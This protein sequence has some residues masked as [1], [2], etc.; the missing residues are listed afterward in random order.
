MIFGGH[1]STVANFEAI[2]SKRH[3]GNWG[4]ELNALDLGVKVLSL[5]LRN[6]S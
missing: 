2:H 6:F 1:V 4:T 5:V 3:S